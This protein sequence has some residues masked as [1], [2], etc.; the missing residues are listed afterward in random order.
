[1]SV[2]SAADVRVGIVSWNTADL[3]DRCLRA[4]PAALAPLTAEVVVVDNAST[5]DVAGVMATHPGVRFIRNDANEG[6]ARAMNRALAGTDAPV[7]IALNPD[8]VPAPGSLSGLVAVL[9]SDAHA[10]VVVPRLVNPD[11][12]LQ[13]S[14]YRFPSPTVSAAAS[15]PPLLRRGWVGRRFWLLGDAPH[16]ASG[17]VDWAVGAVHCIRAAAVDG[18][19]AY[20]ERWFMYVEDLDLCWRVRSAGWRVWFHRDVDVVHVGNAAGDLAWGP[21]R[22]ARWVDA[23]YD[24]YALVHGRLAARGLAL[25][26]ALAVAL[27]LASPGVRGEGR[28][29]Q[30]QWLRLHGRK[31]VFGPRSPSAPQLVEA[32]PVVTG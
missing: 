13:H 21:W 8:T 4:L 19:S 26:S 10:A 17:E 24:W 25:V 20:S 16:D 12:T 14:V 23:T 28:R 27:R 29:E 18:D 30:R 7:L 2:P 3:L 31:L 6:Y 22:T 9:R 5:D 15:L 32:A 11:G 1:M